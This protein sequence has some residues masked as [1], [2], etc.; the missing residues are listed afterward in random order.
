MSRTT[1]LDLPS[2]SFHFLALED[3]SVQ[4]SQKTSFDLEAGGCDSSE[5]TTPASGRR[6]YTQPQ[7]TTYGDL[8]GLTLGGSPGVGESG[9]PFNF[10]PLGAGREQP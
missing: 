10:K 8:R 5:A 2:D 6:P 9:M 7:L 3:S 1:M 4:T